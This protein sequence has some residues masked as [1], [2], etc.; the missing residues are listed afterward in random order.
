M[1]R[2]DQTRR[3]DHHAPGE[4]TGGL[5]ILYGDGFRG[6]L[7]GSEGAFLETVDAC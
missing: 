1:F 3:G 2:P 5:S 7:R 4:R 6:D